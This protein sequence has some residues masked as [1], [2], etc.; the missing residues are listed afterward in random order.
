[1]PKSRFTPDDL[2]SLVLGMTAEVLPGL[3][4]PLLGKLRQIAGA[5][6]GKRTPGIPR[7][8]TTTIVT[9]LPRVPRV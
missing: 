2:D 8:P 3:E 5:G 9:R 4:S 7:A 6:A 1:M